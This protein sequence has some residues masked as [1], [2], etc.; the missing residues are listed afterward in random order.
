MAALEKRY[1]RDSFTKKLERICQRLDEASVRTIA[2]KNFLN[3]LVTSQ[4]EITSLWVVGSYARGALMCGDLDLVLEYKVVDG[5]HPSPSSMTKTFFGTP[6]YVRYYFGTPESS[7]AGVVFEN[8]VHIWNSRGCDW[9]APINSITP[10]PGAGRAE[11]ETDSIPLRPEQ[12]Y[13]EPERLQQLVAQ[14]KDGIIEWDFVEITREALEP[15]PSDTVR[16][17]DRKLI[18][19]APMMGKKSQTLVPAIIRL[20][21]RY[22]PI[23]DWDAS[24]SHRGKLRCGATVLHL[25]RPALPHYPFD[26]EP[27]IEQFALIPHI[28]AKGPNGAWIIRRGPNHPDAQSLGQKSAYYL[29]SEGEPDIVRYRDHDKSW[30]IELLQLF[31]T[32]EDAEVFSAMVAADDESWRIEIGEAKGFELISLFSVADVVEIGDLQFPV[33][34][35]GGAY[36]DRDKATLGELLAA[37]PSLS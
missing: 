25:G 2:Y 24:E 19:V 18:R 5:T 29:L 12:L 32:R 9:R 28:S 27:T 7:T 26:D 10:D 8:A 3:R 14:E 20:M 17:R 16:E 15:I 21:A 37:L 35:A 1:P 6:Q 34:N 4:V 36:F 11:R 13:M 33:T 30:S 22:S 31:S 23:G